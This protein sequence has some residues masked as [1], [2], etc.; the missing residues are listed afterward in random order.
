MSWGGSSAEL[1]PAAAQRQRSERE[2]PLA[3][4]RIEPAA[5]AP[6][7]EAAR[8][9]HRIGASVAGAVQ[10]LAAPSPPELVSWRTLGLTR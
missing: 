5:V 6:S 4:P 8:Y 7:A 10:V 1:Q 2:P 9:L 3:A